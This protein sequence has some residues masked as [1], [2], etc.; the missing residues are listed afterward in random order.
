MRYLYNMKEKHSIIMDTLNEW[1]C[2]TPEDMFVKT[3]LYGYPNFNE[4]ANQLI[5][6]T[7]IYILATKRFSGSLL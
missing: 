6:E 2:T 3:L 7:L 1:I 4:S 5:F